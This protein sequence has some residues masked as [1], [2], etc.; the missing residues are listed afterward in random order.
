MGSAGGPGGGGLEFALGGP[1]GGGLNVG[2]GGGAA[3]DGGPGGGG[4]GLVEGLC[5]LFLF[6]FLDSLVVQ[7][8]DFNNMNFRKFD[9][10]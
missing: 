10:F 7:L 3:F 8:F 9:I 2:K 5:I 1:G 4:G 6:Y